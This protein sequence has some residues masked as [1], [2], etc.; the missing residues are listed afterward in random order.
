MKDYIEVCEIPVFVK[1]GVADQERVIGQ[2][3]KF[4]LKVGIDLSAPGKSDRLQD[5]ISYVELVKTLIEVAQERDFHLLEH[6]CASISERLFERFEKVDQ[7]ALTVAKPHIPNPD[8]RGKAFVSIT[9]S[10]P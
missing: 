10:R 4:N 6:L 5:T 3:L 8:F 7:I 2:E 9:R 1:I